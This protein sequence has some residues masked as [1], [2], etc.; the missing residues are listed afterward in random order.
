MS[1]SEYSG[2]S[3]NEEWGMEW[4]ERFCTDCM[5]IRDPQGVAGFGGLIEYGASALEVADY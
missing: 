5:E 4:I 3:R 2:G 1:N